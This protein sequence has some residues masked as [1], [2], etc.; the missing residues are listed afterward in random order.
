MINGSANGLSTLTLILSFEREIWVSVIEQPLK[1]KRKQ[2]LCASVYHL[3]NESNIF[4]IYL[5]DCVH[6]IESNIAILQLNS[7][8]SHAELVQ[9]LQVKDSNPK[10]TVLISATS[11]GAPR[12]LT[13]LIN[14]L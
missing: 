14:W 4:L 3:H 10:K 8:T 9:I 1:K 13:L 7:D 6:K 2:F 11:S 12:P 5:R